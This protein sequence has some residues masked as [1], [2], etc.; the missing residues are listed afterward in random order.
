MESESFEDSFYVGVNEISTLSRIVSELTIEEDILPTIPLF[1]TPNRTIEGNEHIL[2]CVTLHTKR[3]ILSLTKTKILLHDIVT[4]TLIE[5]RDLDLNV[6]IK[7]YMALL[8]GLEV[9][10]EVVPNWCSISITTGVLRI[11]L[12]KSRVCEAEWYVGKKDVEER[13]N[14]GRW[15]VVFLFKGVLSFIRGADSDSSP[16]KSD[17]GRKDFYD[18][19]DS[20]GDLYDAAVKMGLLEIVLNKWKTLDVNSVDCLVEAPANSYMVPDN[21]IFLINAYSR[22]FCLVIC[23]RILNFRMISI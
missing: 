21:V 15:V 8:D 18:G 20:V 16:T 23:S 22:I 7:R 10:T 19:G 9:V 1:N 5:C 11:T 17:F 14:I 6:D 4:C 13:I 12:D 3:H 2:K